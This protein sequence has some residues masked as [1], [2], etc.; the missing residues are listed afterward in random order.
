MSEE[1]KGGSEEGSVYEDAMSTCMDAEDELFMEATEYLLQN[2]T[3]LGFSSYLNQSISFDGCVGAEPYTSESHSATSS[4]N[5]PRPG[6]SR[7][8]HRQG[9]SNT[10][11]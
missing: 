11:K 3:E 2:N 9:T 4:E 6:T 8:T 7:N 5:N 1:E 10:L